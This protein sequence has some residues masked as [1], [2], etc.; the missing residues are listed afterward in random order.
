MPIPEHFRGTKDLLSCQKCKYNAVVLGICC[1]KY[2]FEMWG[3]RAEE[4]PKCHVCDDFEY[5]KNHKKS[6]RGSHEKTA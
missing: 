6:K 1:R 2:N 4:L 3:D 5:H